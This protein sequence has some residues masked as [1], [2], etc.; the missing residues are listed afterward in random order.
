[1]NSTTFIVYDFHCLFSVRSKILAM[2]AV[3]SIYFLPIDGAGY[4][5]INGS[6]KVSMGEVIFV[7]FQFKWLDF[8]KFPSFNVMFAYTFA[9]GKEGKGG[10]K[11]VKT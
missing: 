4:C 10:G 1:M 11:F 3:W 9:W 8:L 5:T 7:Y 6:F 2:Y